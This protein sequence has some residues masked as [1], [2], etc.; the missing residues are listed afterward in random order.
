MRFEGFFATLLVLCAISYFPGSL[1]RGVEDMLQSNEQLDDDGWYEQLQD[2]N[3]TETSTT[4]D[5]SSNTPD[6]SSNTPDES[7]TT[8]DES[9]T[10][11][12]ESSSTPAE[13]S[14]TPA[15]SSTTPAESST[16]PAESSTTPNEPSP[17]TPP[18]KDSSAFSFV[19]N[20]ML[21]VGATVLTLVISWGR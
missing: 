16:T 21:T 4:P 8:P 20:S 18:N 7:S 11:P 19:G 15:E 5:E 10:T 6:E 3:T 12:D 17:N 9:S 2:R 13:S 14:S 1:Q